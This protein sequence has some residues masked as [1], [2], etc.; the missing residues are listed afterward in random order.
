[1]AM[2]NQAPAELADMD[3]F[4]GTCVTVVVRFS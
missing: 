3:S 4:R 2:V 1:M